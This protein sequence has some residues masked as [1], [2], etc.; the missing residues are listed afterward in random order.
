VFRTS[1]HHQPIRHR[2]RSDRIPAYFRGH[3]T[4]RDKGN[5]KQDQ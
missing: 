1:Q 2:I 5:F 4:I 3:S